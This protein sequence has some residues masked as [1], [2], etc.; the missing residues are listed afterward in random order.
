MT[1]MPNSGLLDAPLSDSRPHLTKPK[2]DQFR[3]LGIIT[4]RDLLY[5]LPRDYEDR[6]R[7]D[8]IADAT[9][10]ARQTFE[11]ITSRVSNRHNGRQYR[12]TAKLYAIRDDEPDE[13]EFLNL[14]WFGQRHLASTIRSGDRLVV[15]GLVNKPGRRAT[16]NQPEHDIIAQPGSASSQPVNTAGI[17]PVYPLTAGMNQEYMRRAILE[18]LH[19]FQPA[20]HRSRPKTKPY[21]L[22]RLLAAIHRPERIQ[23]A[24]HA[25]G[26]LTADE[27]L[28]IQ[29]AL[30][31]LRHQRE[32]NTVTPGLAIDP[33]ARDALM[34]GLP[35]RP[36]DA[37][38]RCMDEIR[39]DL[40][41]TG[42]AM[43][44]LLQGEVGSGK[45]LVALA[46]AVDTAS[47]GGQIAL[48][49]PTSLLAEQ[50]FRTIT[51]LLDAHPSPTTGAST[52]QSRLPGLRRPF[53]IALL[54]A[55]TPARVRHSILGAAQLGTISMLAGTHS[56][57]NEQ[58][59]LPYLKLAIADEQHRFGVAQRA[60]LRHQAH[61]LMLTATPIPR[62]MQ[63]TL[64][65]DLDISTIDAMPISKQPVQ[66]VVLA[67]RQRD[68]AYDAIR[69]AV[70]AGQQAFVIYPLI[71]PSPDVEGLAATDRY[72]RLCAEFDSHTVRMIHGRM[73]PSDRDKELLAFR[74]GETDILVST[75]IVE[76]GIDI[77]NA[78]VM[79][80][81]SSERFGLA[82]LHQLRG[83][84]GRG[85]I[86]GICYIMITP[87]ANP[88]RTTRSRIR[89]I[90][91][92]NDGIKLAEA[93]LYNRGHG[94]IAGT[95]QSGQDTLLHPGLSYDL[96]LLDQEREAAE[97]I[98]AADPHLQLPENQRLQA[99]RRRVLG[100]MTAVD[101]DH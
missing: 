45:T 60:A 75:P 97:R 58:V 2:L 90:R 57:I 100:S 74:N 38:S 12:Q 43:N 61:Y 13:S 67:E 92:S 81:E 76:V 51:E 79:L 85:T 80:I 87:G 86:P 4:P 68:Q 15:H 88:S 46:A 65:R 98:H 94:D 55:Q 66:T 62:T 47:A 93:D 14:A 53:T 82:Q 73:K 91:D 23:D 17:I 16:I 70:A 39:R 21:E 96:P 52:Y 54:T 101:T 10:G 9:D 64:Y 37:Q 40:A 6:R 56:I 24:D 41:H 69:A 5:H 1:G 35:F 59:E 31:E 7:I 8:D 83:R 78:T 18:T 33:A 84:I 63:L 49:A 89:A 36:T 22:H 11:G 30:L 27:L 26:Q 71:D 20:L 48:L 72:P 99:A 95:R 77:P 3:R 44:R 25:L 19:H 32:V 29:L 28:E 42:P 50:H 34:A